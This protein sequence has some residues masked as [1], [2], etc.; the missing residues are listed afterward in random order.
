MKYLTFIT[1]LLLITIGHHVN[2]QNTGRNLKGI[3]T[4]ATSSEPLPFATVA[5]L[6]N[7][8]GQLTR[9]AVSQTALDGT[10]GISNAPADTILLQVSFVG[11]QTAEQHVD[12]R[13]ADGSVRVVMTPDSKLLKEVEVVGEKPPIEIA[14]DKRI[15]NVDK[16][17]T[18]QGGTAEMVLKNVPSVTIDESGAATMRNLTATIYVNGKPT[19]LT[20]AQIP[21][22]QIESVEVISNPSARYDAST[23]GGIINLVLKRNKEQGYNGMLIIGV[24]TNSRYDGTLNLD[25][26]KGKWNISGL[27]SFNSTKN[28]LPSSSYRISKNPNGEPIAYFDQNTSL[29]QDNTFQSGRISADYKFNDRNTL[30]I[31]GSLAGG[32]FN[33]STEQNYAYRNTDDAII[34]YG[35][36]TTTPHND[37][38]NTGIELDWKHQFSQKGREL[39]FMSSFT[40]NRVSNAGDWYTTAYDIVEGTSVPQEGYPVTNQIDGSITGNQILAQLDYVHPLN[41]SSKL[42]FGA[43]SFTYLRDQ[44]YLF[45]EVTGESIRLLEDYS[46]NAQ[47]NETVNAV[48]GLYSHQ[49][50]KKMN[51]QGGLRLEQSFLHGK[52]RFDGS[53]FGYNYPSKTGQNIFQSIF[54]SLSFNNKIN[55]SSEWNVSLSRKVGRPSFRHMFVGIQAND[56]QNI[57]IGNPAVRPEFVNTAEA[58]YNK[59]WDKTSGSSLQWLVTGYYIYEDHTIKPVTQPDPEDSTILVTTFQNVKADIQYGVD[60][61][62][63]YS[64][65]NLSLLGNLNIFEVILQSTEV[66]TRMLRYNAKMNLTYKFPWGISAQ[67]S[68]QYRSKSAQLQGYQK[69]IAGADFALRKGFWQNR[70]AVTFIINDIFNSRVQYTVYDQPLTYQN[71]MNRRDIRYYKISLQLPLSKNTRKMKEKKAMGPDIDF[72]N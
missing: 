11:Y 5:L 41:E 2:G 47:I 43:R 39:S 17:L 33:T 59:T 21:A 54:P 48:Y 18:S 71:T 50:N 8:D 52:S 42:E 70:G 55:E 13:T 26:Q 60:N 67:L 4:D 23:S 65:G 44:Q 68:G 27:Y 37:Y 7:K 53:T 25:Y 32:V 46:Q 14:P 3:V 16:N 1:V 15:F 58:S 28:P 30:T 38:I 72:S 57:T 51:W 63:T 69:A 19:Q 35:N 6:Q 12:L 45:S 34:S 22:N 31:A 29:K 9:I 64:I 62:L 61:T 20:L 49:I 10:F 66:T 40:H 56:K 36:R 24:G